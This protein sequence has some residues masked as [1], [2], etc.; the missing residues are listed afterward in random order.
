MLVEY[1]NLI[2]KYN[3]NDLIDGLKK[4]QIFFKGTKIGKKKRLELNKEKSKEE[5]RKYSGF[6]KNKY[7]LMLVEK[8]IHE[9][10]I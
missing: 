8:I 3:Y 9:I 1:Y 7:I 10:V 4:A 5:I 6:E 2:N